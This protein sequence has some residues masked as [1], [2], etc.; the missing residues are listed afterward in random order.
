MLS[1]V[2]LMTY[3]LYYF[4]MAV[5]CETFPTKILNNLV[6]LPLTVLYN[7]IVNIY[8]IIVYIC[9]NKVILNLNLIF[10]HANWSNSKHLQ[11][12]WYLLI[13]LSICLPLIWF[14]WT[15]FFV[16]FILKNFS[17]SIKAFSTLL[18]ICFFC[19]SFSI[20]RMFAFTLT[21]LML[22]AWMTCVSNGLLIS[23]IKI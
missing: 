9:T 1:P 18:I 13:L 3:I 20:I 2:T 23:I 17:H 14:H 8:F 5:V 22:S 12:R 7:F 16:L 10:L 4:K 21:F 19:Q 11:F 15:L 6:S